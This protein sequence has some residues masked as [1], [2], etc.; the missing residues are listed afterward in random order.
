MGVG[1]A[2]LTTTVSAGRAP[3]GAES[4]GVERVVSG[5]ASAARLIGGGA[6]RIGRADGN[7]LELSPSLG[8][9]T[10]RPTVASSVSVKA[11]SATGDGPRRP[12]RGI[13][14][15]GQ[16]RASVVTGCPHLRHS[17]SVPAQVC[18]GRSRVSGAE[19]CGQVDATLSTVRPQFGHLM[20]V[21]RFAFPVS[22]VFPE[23]GGAP[24][25]PPASQKVPHRLVKQP[26]SNLAL[27]RGFTP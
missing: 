26:G 12:G 17:V 16:T 20:S 18:G 9:T 27:E 25:I 7:A 22:G 10:A 1:G 3:P 23:A 13:E 15:C 5:A 19:H 14:Q 6:A 8:T 11:A 21:T 4:T 2:A 24:T